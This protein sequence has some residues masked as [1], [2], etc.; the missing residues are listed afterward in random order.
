MEFRNYNSVL[1]HFVPG[2]VLVQS[3]NVG[4][5]TI[6]QDKQCPKHE[7]SLSQVTQIF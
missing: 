6:Q 3:F 2:F 7:C 4:Y 5:N 1:N